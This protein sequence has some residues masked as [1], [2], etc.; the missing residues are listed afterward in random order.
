M[1]TLVLDQAQVEQLLT[2]PECIELMEET[3]VALAR[4]E[5]YQP[6]RSVVRPPGAD[7]FM[8]LMP[9]HRGGEEPAFGLKVVCIFPGNPARGLDAHQGAVVLFDGETG[10]VRAIVN[11]SAIVAV[12]SSRVVGMLEPTAFT[13]APSFSHSRRT[14]GSRDVVVV[15][16]T[17]ASRNA[18]SAVSATSTP[19]C[20]ACSRVRLQTTIRS[21]S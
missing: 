6:L 5:L 14:T 13:W 15:Q 21:Q 17:S 16:T 2:M 11:A 1:S 7:G 9:A 12:S 3:L 19:S 18:S 4:E 20:S 8:G 10:E